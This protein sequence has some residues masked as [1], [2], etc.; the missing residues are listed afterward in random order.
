MLK[1]SVAAVRHF[2][3][4]LSWQN[5]SEVVNLCACI[6]SAESRMEAVWFPLVCER[7]TIWT[8]RFSPVKR[9]LE[10]PSHHSKNC[11]AGHSAGCNG[12]SV[13][14]KKKKNHC[15]NVFKGSYVPPDCR[16]GLQ[17]NKVLVSGTCR[18]GKNFM[19][20]RQN[21][22]DSVESEPELFIVLL[23]LFAH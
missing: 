10:S 4:I 18:C 22:G 5:P 7:R 17:R 13:T 14:R 16:S 6:C 11:S 3:I 12:P 1:S 21:L 23:L 2:G 8:Q 15:Y 19:L 9:H 20:F